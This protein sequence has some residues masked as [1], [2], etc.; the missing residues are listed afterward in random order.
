MHRKAWLTVLILL[1]LIIIAIIYGI[2][3]VSIS[4]IGGPGPLETS[5]A[6]RAR[7]WYISRAARAVPASTVPNDSAAISAGEGIYGMECASCH[8]AD[9]RTPTPIGKAM[10]PRVPSLASPA[11]QQLSDK[12]LFWIIKNGVRLSGMPGFGGIDTDQE[13]W[14][15]VY[16]V[17]S[18]GHAVEH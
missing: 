10:Y 16:Y 12:E 18:L 14:Q 7:G 9:G 3:H 6:T 2:M 11:V 15:T 13:I 5:F 8:G 17:R 4:A 1:V